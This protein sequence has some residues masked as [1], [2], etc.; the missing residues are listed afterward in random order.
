MATMLET[1]SRIWRRIEAIEEQDMPSLPS[2]PPFEDSTGEDELQNAEINDMDNEESGDNM[3]TMSTRIH[4][5]PASTHHT[6]TSTF[7]A[8]G[9]SSST[10]RFAQSIESRSNKSLT[11]PLSVR[12]MPSRRSHHDSFEVPSLPHIEPAAATGH[13]SEE[14]DE[15]MESRSSVPEVYLPPEEDEN[16]DREDRDFSLTDALDQED[17]PKK[18]QEFS[19]SAASESKPSPFEK[20]RNV[21]LRRTNPRAR[22]PSLSRTSSSPTT[23]PTQS[24]PRSNRSLVLPPSNAPSPILAARVPLPRSRTASPAVVVHNSEGEEEDQ[25]FSDGTHETRS[26]D[27]TDVHISPPRL[28]DDEQDDD[29]LTE[30][31]SHEQSQHHEQQSHTSHDDREPTFSSEG[32][33][34]PYAINTNAATQ[35]AST[36]S[37]PSRS[38]AFTPTPAFPRPRAR[39]DLPPPP[40]E[41]LAT[42]APRAE[43]ETTRQPDNDM[44]ATPFNK[45]PSFLLSVINSTARPRMTAGT[46]HPRRF[47]GSSVVESTAAPIS[48]DPTSAPNL[49][50]ALAG[51]TPR[52][53]IAIARRPSHPL[54][55]TA[56]ASSGS[57]QSVSPGD[58]R[59]AMWAT[60]AHSSPYD[61]AGDRASF[62]STASSHDL[63]T[64]QRANTSFDPAMGFGAGAP[65]HGVGRFNAGKLNTYLH[66]LN[67]RLQ[68][69]NE[70]LVERLRRLEEEKNGGQPGDKSSANFDRR[71]SGG[72]RRSSAGTTLGNVQ[73]DMAEAWLEEK[74]ELEEVI[75]AF[76]TEATTYMAEKEEV[77]YA[78]QQEKEEREKDKVR[79]R[80]RMAEVEHGVS[81]IVTGLEEKLAAAEKE[82]KRIEQEATRRLKEMERAVVLLEG[83]RDVAIDRASKAER[84]LENGKD[85]GGALKEA[86]ERVTQV[87]ADLRN[88]NAQI[89]Q[90]EDQVMEYDGRIDELEAAQKDDANVIFGLENELAAASDALADERVRV[91]DLE[92]SVRRLNKDLA[93]TKEYV[94]ELESDAVI[95]DQQ[96]GKLRKDLDAA[97][98][99]LKMMSVTEQQ[100]AQDIEALEREAEEAQERVQEMQTALV[101]AERQ[102][103]DDQEALADL[104]ARVTSLER[105]RERSRDISTTPVQVGPSEAEYDTLENELNDAEKEIARLNAL[106]KQSPARKAIDKAKDIKIE[107]LER[108][109]EELLERNRALRMTFNEFSTPNKIINSSGI[110]PIHRQVLS[111]SI[112][113]PKTPG[114][115]LKD[116]SWLNSVHDP[117]VSPLISEIGRLQQQLDRA[118]ESIDDKLDKLEDA[119]LGVVG[120]TKKLEDA[121]AKIILLEDEIARLN[122]REE[123]KARRLARARCQKCNIKLDL[124]SLTQADE[125]SFNIPNDNLPNE[126]PTPPTRT[127]EALKANIQA[128]NNHLEQLKKQWEHEKERLMSEKAVLEN[129]ANRLN[130][131]V[132]SSQ[133]QARKVAESTRV[134]D[135]AKATVQNELEKAKQTISVLENELT[136]ER[137][138]LRALVAEQEK[139]ER[140]KKQI[141]ADMQRTESDMDLVK[142]ELQKAKKENASL[143]KELRENAN[144][145]QKARHLEARVAEKLE[146]IERLRQERSLLAADHKELQQRFTAVSETTNKLRKEYAAHSTSHDNRRHELDLHRLEID[147]LRRALDERAGDLQRAEKEKEK[148]LSEK[149]NVVRTVAALEADLKRV[150]RDAEAFGRDLKLLR[151]EKEKLEA[152][153]KEELSKAERAKKQ[154]LTQIRLLNEQLETQKDETGR[155]LQQLK[156]HVC[157]ADE[158][159]ISKLKLQHNKE[160]KGLIVQIRYLKAK[161]T[162][163]STFR[164][165]LTYQKQYLL[166]LL[167]QFEKSERTIFASIARIG[168]PVAPP[169]S[170]RRVP[171][172]KSLV[173]TAVFF[174][175]VRKSSD[176]WRKENTSKHA[177]AQALQDVRR[178]RV[179]A[180]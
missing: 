178:R 120:L 168:F 24:T 7:R 102:S 63:T 11:G 38:I 81:G 177:I 77:E 116:L 90:L 112:R 51:V 169:P 128:V 40:G 143:E 127:S 97:Q 138:R 54:S 62:I 86:N 141:L 126:P 18:G 137:S 17:T 150:R 174:L 71:L 64:H 148:V 33:A 85:L 13:Y 22:T 8:P 111:M 155:A 2:L 149:I 136:S 175:R 43:A 162:R 23:S 50:P 140:E 49:Q 154:T 153:N 110:S 27:I 66:G 164:N 75:E 135:K 165:D 48:A 72:R 44:L 30:T 131:Q 28:N 45:R 146:T 157:A 57:R 176:S 142:E 172:L 103:A 166:I 37:S 31:E 79:W 34:T 1:P 124:R 173:L 82:V 76:R 93:G 109:K 74:A 156:S 42:P 5:T 55:Q 119:G 61:G 107:M 122:R 9:S 65:G 152:K 108:E 20:Y 39:F 160:C 117:S 171:K 158:T 12:G 67:R 53:R 25:T 87:M 151:A 94:E 104:R 147:E 6:L 15:D 83:E 121:R 159:Q 132:K 69:E 14:T 58:A 170:R 144:A 26:M 46:P 92:S 41:I 91:K 89:K 180:S 47:A 16:P 68:E 125:S 139:K 99:T 179:A 70:A 161:F 113:A 59:P 73:E 80:E 96:M 19:F 101:E 123:R 21:A 60:P 78:L 145:D 84:L 163:E 129:A 29:I 56:S 98:E 35:N 115:P 133:E 36:F 118:N 32:D 95:A 10:A 167:T 114:A 4:S 130:G 134:A 88:A 52:P 105:E 106:L 100:N 3:E